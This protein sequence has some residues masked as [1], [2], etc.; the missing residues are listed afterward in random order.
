MFKNLL[1]VILLFAIKASLLAQCDVRI[2]STSTHICLG[3]S[4]MLK[5]KGGCGLVLFVDFN[6]STLQG[7]TSNANQYIGSPCTPSLDNT[8][9]LW[10]G[11]VAGQSLIYTQNLNVS[12][13]SYTISFEMRYGEEGDPPPCD[14]PSTTAESVHLQYSTNNGAS[15]TD[16]QYWDPNGGHDANLIHWNHYVV[17]LPTAA[18]TASTRFRWTQLST[19]PANSSCWG[20]DNIL[21]QKYVPTQYVWSTGHNGPNPPPVS[22]INTTT[23]HVTATAGNNSSQDSITILVSPRPTSN[24]ITSRPLCKDDLIDFIYTGNGDSTATYHWSLSNA[25]Q[26]TDTNKAHA[27]ASWNKAGQYT[28]SLRVTQGYCTSLPTIKELLI[29]PL[30]SFYISSSQGCEPLEVSYTGNVEPPNSNYLWDFH[31]GTTDTATNPVHIYQTAGNYGLTLIATT[32]SGCVDTVSF[33]ALTK[34]YPTPIVDFSWNPNIIPW[35]DPLASFIDKSTYGNAYQWDFG[36]PAGGNSSSPNPTH[37]YSEKGLFDVWL[38]VTSEHGCKDSLMKSIRVVDDVFETPNIIT[39]NGDGYNDYF[40]ITNIESLKNC[41]IEVFN[42]WGK[43]VYIHH[44]YKN[45]W[46]PVELADGTYY[47]YINYESYF[48]KGEIHGFFYVLKK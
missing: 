38:M 21:I 47:Y 5:A 23:Y 41:H 43:L 3:D 16:I 10:M 45:Q 11:T 17:G 40:E 19:N 4:V 36:D 42:R 25:S 46:S 15:W 22:P 24:F 48:G 28:T 2:H 39:P 27:F 29:A 33:P 1:I 37:N 9:Y 30:I 31:D 44:N 18:K 32:D 34:V 6:D 35:S 14:G 8:H 20:I 26:Q 7:L 12:S 13:G